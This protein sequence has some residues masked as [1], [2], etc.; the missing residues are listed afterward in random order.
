ME[1]LEFIR[2]PAALAHILE[3]MA[4]LGFGMPSEER[5]GALSRTIAASK[6]AGRF[7]ELGTG[8]GISTA[9]LLDGMD[10]ASQLVSVDVDARFQGVAREVFSRDERLTLAAEDAIS[11]LQSQE[12]G[13]FD[14]VFADAMAGK[15]EGLDEALRVLSAGGF[16]V[17]DDMLP[18]ANWPDGPSK[19]MRW[20]SP[21]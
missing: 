4:E 3:R 10:A 7:L 1:E 15:Y 20:L 6:P 21:H 11:F 8:T 19:T 14:F 16:Y 12:A 2:P 5:T 17:I 9:W 13:S 18:Q